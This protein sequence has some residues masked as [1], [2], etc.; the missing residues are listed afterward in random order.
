MIVTSEK[1]NTLLVFAL[2]LSSICLFFLLLFLTTPN[3]LATSPDSIAYLKGAYGYLNGHGYD[4]VSSEWPPF[5]PTLLM[6]FGSLAQ[7]D[8]MIGVRLLHSLLFA[9]SFLIIYQIARKVILSSALTT[10]L[11]AALFC[12]QPPIIQ[13]YFYVWSEP[14]LIVLLLTNIFT[15]QYLFT[16]PNVPSL[17]IELL[18]MVLASAAFLTRFSGICVAVLNGTMLFLHLKNSPPFQR[19]FRSTIQIILPVIVFLPWLG[20]AGVSNGPATQRAISFHPITLSTL[21]YGLITI[22]NWF[23]PAPALKENFML[24]YVAIFIGCAVVLAI[25][26]WLLCQLS[27]SMLWGRSTTLGISPI[28]NLQLSL[29]MFVFIYLSF[30]IAALSFVD[31]KVVLDNRILSPMYV[32]ISLM[33]IGVIAQIKRRSVRILSIVV[34]AGI[35]L[36][37]YPALRSWLLINYHNGVE[38]SDKNFKNKAIFKFVKTCHKAAV[39]YAENP[40]HFDLIFES[41]VMWL[42]KKVLFNTGKINEEYSAEVSALSSRADLIIV[43]SINSEVAVQVSDNKSFTQIYSAAD[44]LIW[45]NIR[46]KHPICER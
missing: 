27:Q 12:I 42:P 25:V 34:L 45:A 33:I 32:C 20:H 41:K 40:W 18:L 38:L 13:T 37:T 39:V 4:Y 6:L 3:G 46:A 8:V 14:T 31:D 43:E 1:R 22:G 19:I 36:T 17:N 2:V 21:E 44:G 11:V 5:F 28:E 30:L 29:A 15:L 35:L 10:T 24:K 9:L 26:V 16:R 7:N 23:I